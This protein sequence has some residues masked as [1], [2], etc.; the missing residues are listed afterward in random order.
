MKSVNVCRTDL[1]GTHYFSLELRAQSLHVEVKK[2]ER[3]SLPHL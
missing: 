3:G 2:R 1:E